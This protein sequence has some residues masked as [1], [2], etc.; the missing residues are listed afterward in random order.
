MTLRLIEGGRGN[1]DAPG[2]LIHGASQVAT[3]AGG[4]RRGAAQADAAVLD[5]A[6][7]RRPGL[8]RRAGRRVLGR[9][10]RRRRPAGGRGTSAR[11]GW[12]RARPV[13]TPRRGRRRRDARAGRPAHAPAVRRVA[14]AGARPAPARRRLSRDPRRRRRDP[15]DRR[16]DARRDPRGARGATAAAGSTRC[17]RTGSRRSRRSPATASTS[18]PS[19][20]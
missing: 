10:H 18:P 1:T 2:L 6:R 11:G 17:S 13:R 9:P 12:L 14:R 19:C 5:A 15:V 4:L 3:L 8:A 20:A 7:R 16:D